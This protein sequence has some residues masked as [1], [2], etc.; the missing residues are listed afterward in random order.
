MTKLVMLM[1]MC[2]DCKIAVEEKQ[3]DTDAKAFVT[4]VISWKVGSM[5]EE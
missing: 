2:A 5:P 4:Y 3:N 1:V